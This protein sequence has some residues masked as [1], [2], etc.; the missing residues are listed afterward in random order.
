MKVIFAVF[1]GRRRFLLVLM[2][3]LR[4][5]LRSREVDEAHLWDYCRNANDRELVKKLVRDEAQGELG[6]R[7]K[8]MVPPASDATAR[9]P[10]K[11][12]GFYAH[13]ADA[14]GEDDLLIKCDDDVVFIANLHVLLGYARADGK[15][16]VYY[17]SVVNNDVSAAFQAADGLITDPEFALELRAS[18]AEGAYSRTP[19]SD[20]YN[21]SACAEFIHRRFLKQPEAFFTG[22]VH[23]WRL[24]ARVPINVFVMRGDA[25]RRTFGAYAAEAFVDEAYLTALVTE[26]SHAPSALVTDAVVVHFSF[27]FQHMAAQRELLERYRRL[28]HDRTLLAQLRASFGARTLNHSCPARAPPEL[29]QGRR[30]L[31]P[32]RRHGA[33]ARRGSG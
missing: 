25:V 30:T 31:H 11:W 8:L 5:L 17:P 16:Q 13:Y 12:K 27:A 20:W 28:S 29:L 7:V 15:H 21:C 4:P 9:F 18:R 10:N 1:A 22:C 19:I 2:N 14:V 3:Y 32:R 24:P 6:A 33:T 23:E 26:R